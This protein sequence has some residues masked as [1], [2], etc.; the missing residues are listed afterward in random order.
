[1]HRVLLR[2]ADRHHRAAPLP[3]PDFDAAAAKRW[4][5]VRYYTDP[6]YYNDHD[7]VRPYRVGM[8]CAFCHVGPNPINP[9]QNPEAPRWEEL[10]S[11]PGAQYYWVERI[12]FW[13]T[14]P[15]SEAGRPRP[16]RGE[17]PVPAFP[18]QPAG[19][20]GYIAGVVGLHEQP[21]TMNA[22]YEVGARLALARQLGIESWKA[23]ERT[24]PSSRTIRRPPPLPGF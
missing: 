12:F 17:L 18:H 6:D 21:R 11:N 19:V 3:N 24:T 5:P 16:E 14:R 23:G 15:R 9:P 20:A 22:V 8:S 4:D 7:L 10:T 13:N 1:M 2:R